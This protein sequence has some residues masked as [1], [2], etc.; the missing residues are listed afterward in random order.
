[1]CALFAIA[2]GF[3]QGTADIRGIVSDQ[4]GAVIVNAKV[5]LRNE[6]QGW[7]R[8]TSSSDI[9]FFLFPAVPV[10][11]YAIRIEASGFQSQTRS[12]IAVQAV[13]QARVDVTLQVGSSAE[14]VNVSENAEQVNTTSSTLKTVVDR[15]RVENLPL[16]GRNPLQLLSLLPGGVPRG[17]I[18]Q[19]IATPTFSVNGAAQDQINYRLDGGDHMDTWFGSPLSY[20]NPDAL[21]EFT[22]QTNNFSA[23]YGRNAGAVVDAVV[24]S[25]TNQLHGTLFEYFRNDKLDARPFFATKRPSFHRNQFGA[26]VGGPI[27]IPHVYDGKD[28][29]F[30]FFSWQTTREVGSPGVSTYTTLSEKQRAGD[31]SELRGRAIVDPSTGQPFPG[32]II[33]QSRLSVP[34]SNFVKRYLPL[35]T[36]PN[37]TDTF[38]QGGFANTNQFLTRI[39]QKIGTNDN[40]AFRFLYNRPQ[41]LT[42]YGAGIGPGQSW[43]DDYRVTDQSYTLDETHIFS[44]T[45]VN[46]FNFTFQHRKHLMTPRTVFTWKELGAHFEPSYGALPDNS[47]A[48]AGYFSTYSGFFWDNGRNNPYLSNELSIVRGK[49]SLSV[50]GELWYSLIY[51]R[52]PYYVGGAASFSGQFSGDRAADF[53]LGVVNSWTQQSANEIDL[54]QWRSALYV[55][56]DFKASPRLMFNLGVRWEPY[57][58]YYETFG[59]QGYWAPGHQSTRF[60]LAPLGQLFAFDNDPAIPNRETIINKDWNNFAPRFG[61]AWDP[62]GKQKWSIRGGYGMFSMACLSAS[63]PFEA[64]ITSPSRA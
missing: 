45:I 3:G 57:L 28:K 52:T 34:V 17:P 49:H 64:S 50:G 2:A 44:P 41:G 43:F 58:P 15:Q 14:V 29:S 47:V 1:L 60:P 55:H 23:K 6:A 27:V 12:G 42:T 26:T 51:N 53:M 8:E 5:Q 39:D 30:W 10:G 22:V 7:T 19:F 9:G 16:N 35:P 59:R 13:T 33:P 24:R 38:P 18:D 31:F 21:Q 63:E 36:G 25:G 56:D 46:H 40:L 62:T 20:P 48:V 32:N 61:F 11:E 54:R 4:S 37:N